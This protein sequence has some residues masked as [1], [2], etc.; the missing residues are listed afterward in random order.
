MN[1]IFILTCSEDIMSVHKDFGHAVTRAQEILRSRWPEASV[2][3]GIKIVTD[4]HT[5]HTSAFVAKHKWNTYTIKAHKV[6]K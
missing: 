1:K 3:E 2:K 6:E 4:K 5:K